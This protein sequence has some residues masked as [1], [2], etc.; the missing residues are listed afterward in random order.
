MTKP[1][2]S[3]LALITLLSM[4]PLMVGLAGCAGDRHNQVTGPSIE[5]SRTAE[6]VREAVAAGADYKYDRVKVVVGNGIVQLIGFVNTS[7]QRKRAGEVA[8]KVL[9]V[10]EVVNGITVKG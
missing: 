2:A 9:G 5:D 1:S 6:R 3:V 7:A 4:L 10:R 8:S